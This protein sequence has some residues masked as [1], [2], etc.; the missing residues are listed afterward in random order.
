MPS[1]RASDGVRLDYTECD[2]PPGRPVL[3]LAGFKAPATSWLYQLPAL[4][5]YRVFA[6]D[7]RGHGSSEHPEAAADMDRRG[8]DLHDVIENLSLS[9]VKGMDQKVS[10]TDLELLRDHAKR[11]WRPVLAEAP[12]PVLFVA[13]NN[14]ELWPTAHAAAAAELGK[15]ATAVVIDK[16]GHVAN[17]EQPDKFN[18]AMLQFLARV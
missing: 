17:V 4:A 3:L 14:S 2:N 18:A 9:R 13:G 10:A 5:D 1:L 6:V 11:D 8:Q 7:L 16:C 15:Q 12:F